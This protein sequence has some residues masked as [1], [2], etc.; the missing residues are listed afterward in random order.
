VQ[1]TTSSSPSVG[2]SS[3]VSQS[4]SVFTSTSVNP[5]NPTSDDDS[6]SLP[7]TNPSSSAI[8]DSYSNEESSDESQSEFP[9]TSSE[10]KSRETLSNHES[11]TIEEPSESQSNPMLSQVVVPSSSVPQKNS[12]TSSSVSSSSVTL[13]SIDDSSSE[14]S[15][16]G[17]YVVVE[18]SFR[19]IQNGVALSQ[20]SMTEKISKAIMNQFNLSESDVSVTVV[21]LSDNTGLITIAVASSS[22]S[23]MSLR[24]SVLS[25]VDLLQ[26]VQ[27]DNAQL[28]ESSSEIDLGV[29]LTFSLSL[30]LCIL[31]N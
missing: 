8:D 18:I 20:D 3:S 25:N 27:A 4:S 17:P 26:S 7:G 22:I 19:K 9:A 16:P 2:T 10:E 14:V 6:S 12:V 28:E 15:S 13:S 24:Q 11:S 30:L 23:E 31:A 21:S 1:S 29:N 5:S